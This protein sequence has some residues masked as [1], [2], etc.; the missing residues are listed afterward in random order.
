MA[1]KNQ[2]SIIKAYVGAFNWA[3]ASAAYASALGHT[4]P[5]TQ[6]NIVVIV[7]PLNFDK[8]RNLLK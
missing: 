1:V 4:A 5:S 2:N 8:K 7:I 6:L 3:Q